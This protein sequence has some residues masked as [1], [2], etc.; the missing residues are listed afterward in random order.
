MKNTIK[1]SFLLLLTLPLCGCFP[2]G[3]RN[4]GTAPERVKGFDTDNIVVYETDV[5]TA[6]VYNAKIHNF[7]HDE[8]A[9]Y[10]KKMGIKEQQNQSIS[11]EPAEDYS[12]YKLNNGGSVSLSMHGINYSIENEYAFRYFYTLSNIYVKYY[13]T[14]FLKCQY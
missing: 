2:T 7:A 5:K 12:F 11:N 1:R 9:D 6:S 4:T 13:I 14:L 10:F 3:Q 8:L